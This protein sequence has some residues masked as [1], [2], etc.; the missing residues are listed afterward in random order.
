MTYAVNTGAETMNQTTNIW[1]DQAR[2]MIRKH[3]YVEALRL[4][5]LDAERS[6]MGTASSAF[7]IATLKEIELAATV[8]KV[9]P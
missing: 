9:L 7:A 3:G 2:T 8:G 5:S 4:A 1:R 6:T